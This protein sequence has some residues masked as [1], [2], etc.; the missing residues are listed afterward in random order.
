MD[1]EDT[2]TQ[3]G[4]E[5]DVDALLERIESGTGEGIVDA[6]AAEAAPE[7]PQEWAAPD[8]ARFEWNGK[9]IFPDSA[10]KAKT[11]ISQGYNYSQRMGDLNRHQRELEAQR[12]EW[13]E[14]IKR[15]EEM[16]KYGKDNPTWVEHLHKTWAERN[17]PANVSPELEPVLKPIMEKLDKY[18]SLFGDIEKQ[19]QE[20]LIKQQD[21]ALDAEI[22][23]IRKKHPN[24]DLNATDG[25][26]ETLEKRIY[27]HAN[28]HGIPTFRA[29]FYDHLSDKLIEMSKAN[30]REEI[31]KGQAAQAKKGILGTSPAPVRSISAS[32]NVRGKSY[33]DL[34]DEIKSELNIMRG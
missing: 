3:P 2:Q 20:T 15:W 12:N 14:K 10:D 31:A 24:I 9:Q 34:T 4:T 28:Q 22:E 11:W 29:A 5:E 13:S 25:S 8:W 23:A 6:P 7:K 21:Q 18:E 30:G 27:R 16:D 19:K 1:P 33:D 26:G 32:Q 17:R